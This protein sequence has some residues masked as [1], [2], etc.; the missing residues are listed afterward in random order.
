VTLAPELA[1]KLGKL[2]RVIC[3]RSVDGET[4][5]AAGRLSAIVAAHDLDWDRVLNG[6][7]PTRDQM[8]ELFNAGYERGHADGQQGARPERDWTPTGGSAEVGSDAERIKTILD[9]A[10]CAQ[11]AGI[12]TDWEEQF[13]ESTHDRFKTY[14]NRMYVSEKQWVALDRLETKMRRAGII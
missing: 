1:G 11:L 14:G 13:F 7:G 6:G 3:D 9:A 8:Q 12:L 10:S 4:L 5:A 2:L